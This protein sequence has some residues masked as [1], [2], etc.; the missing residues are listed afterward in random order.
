MAT[1]T[2]HIKD[3][4]YFYV[5]QNYENYLNTNQIDFIPEEKLPEII[6]TIYIDRKD[7]IKIF[8]L[9]AL[10]K[11]LKEEYPGDQTIKNLLI[12]IF[13]D[14]ELCKNRLLIEIKVY[15]NSKQNKVDYKKLL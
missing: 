5:K 11:M 4:I 14:D 8:I 6:N 2:K 15:Q 7:H 10:K 13:Q 12:N 3:L 9:D 1:L